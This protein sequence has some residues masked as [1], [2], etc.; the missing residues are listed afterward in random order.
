MRIDEAGADDAAGRVKPGRGLGGREV[1]DGGDLVAGDADVGAV[2]EGAGAVHDVSAG[3]DQVKGGHGGGVYPL[4]PWPPLSRRDGREGE[5]LSSGGGR[6]AVP[7]C[8]PQLLAPAKR[9]ARQTP[10][11]FGED[12][13]GEGAG[14]DVAGVVRANVDA[15]EADG[16]GQRVK[17]RRAGRPVGTEHKG[18]REGRRGVATGKRPT[19]RA[20]AYDESAHDVDEGAAAAEVS[21]DGQ[22]HGPGCTDHARDQHGQRAPAALDA[23]H[24]GSH[25]RAGP[26]PAAGGPDGDGVGGA[27]RPT[28]VWKTID[29]QIHPRI[30]LLERPQPAEQRLPEETSSAPHLRWRCRRQSGSRFDLLPNGGWPKD[31]LRGL[32]DRGRLRYGC[33][34]LGGGMC[35][36]RGGLAGA[37]S[38][39]TLG[40][41]DIGDCSRDA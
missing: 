16:G 41:L 40:V 26:N 38:G 23:E 36:D 24:S 7:L 20:L 30:E 8:T 39:L 10:D 25:K 15:A 4:T 6:G 14:E 2:G 33:N 5:G 1:A 37:I 35:Q 21:L 32:Q 13:A 3:D 12:G 29:E 34:G 31:L 22:L 17:E 19:A 27:V 9:P 18:T 28:R 11:G